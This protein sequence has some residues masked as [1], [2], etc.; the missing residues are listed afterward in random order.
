VSISTST[1]HYE[2]AGSTP[3]IFDVLLQPKEPAVVDDIIE[4]SL[5]PNQTEVDNAIGD[6]IR[7]S[8]F[9]DGWFFRHFTSPHVHQHEGLQFQLPESLS[10]LTSVPKD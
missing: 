6:G 4:S 2:N 3:E 8:G 5:P 1:Q 9:I 10:K 7:T